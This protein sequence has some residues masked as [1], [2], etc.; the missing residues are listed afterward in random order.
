MILFPSENFVNPFQSDSEKLLL[1][2]E[3]ALSIDFGPKR[4]FIIAVSSDQP[5][6]SRLI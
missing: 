4:F 1:P 6:V 5:V 3:A 2:P